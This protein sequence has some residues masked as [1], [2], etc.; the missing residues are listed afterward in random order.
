[1]LALYVLYRRCRYRSSAIMEGHSL[2]D[3]DTNIGGDYCLSYL[4]VLRGIQGCYLGDV[5][6]VPFTYY[7]VYTI[8]SGD[9]HRFPLA[10][11]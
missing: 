9:Y 10:S 8:L 3:T 6:L 11:R 2:S 1:M 5:D 4:V 7:A